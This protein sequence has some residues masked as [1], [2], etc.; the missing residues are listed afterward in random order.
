MFVDRTDELAMLQQLLNRQRSE[1][2][3]LYGRRRVGKTALL[4]HWAS[5]STLPWT[6]WMAQKEP[7]ELQRRKLYAAIRGRAATSTAPTFASW[8]EL[9]DDVARSFVMIGASWC[10]M[11][12]PGRSRPMARCFRRS[13]MPGISTSCNPT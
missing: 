8:S 11:S 3:L 4:R 7:A 9:W 13:S 2:L 6:Y 10:S 5:Q 12:S 1:L